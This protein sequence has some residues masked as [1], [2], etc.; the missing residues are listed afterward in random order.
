MAFISQ[1]KP[2]KLRY[3]YTLFE[4]NRNTGVNTAYDFAETLNLYRFA[5]FRSYF[6]FVFKFVNDLS[7]S[8]FNCYSVNVQE[9]LVTTWHYWLIFEKLQNLNFC[10]EIV[11]NGYYLSI[12]MADDI[13]FID[14]FL[15]FNVQT[16]LNVF[17]WLGIGNI[18][19][20]SIL[21]SKN[22]AGNTTWHDFQ[23]FSDFDGTRFNFS[24][25]KYLTF[26]FINYF[27]NYWNTKRTVFISWRNWKI[28]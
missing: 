28:I 20:F 11:R 8:R 6:L 7:N 19:F 5:F 21:N 2:T 22:L 1:D 27:I 15:F 9:A 23:N 12:T 13:T 25:E 18:F 17:T 14:F 16:K 10:F 24:S 26:L 4:S 3:V